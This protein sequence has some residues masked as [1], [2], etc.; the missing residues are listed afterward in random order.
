M[1]RA[2]FQLAL[3]KLEPSNWKRFEEF[4]SAFLTTE[5]AKLRTVASP[6]G[7]EGRDAELFSA[8]GDPTIVFQYSVA[9]A[10]AAKVRATITKIKAN[11][12]G[13]SLLIYVTNQQIGAAADDL[14]RETRIK[15]KLI[16][17]IFDRSYFLDRF[18]GDDHRET[19]AEALA[20]DVVDQFLEGRGVIER[21][22]Q[23]L[24]NLEA[25]AALLFLAL[26][27]EDDTREKG[28][29]ALAFEALVR[30]ALRGTDSDRKMKRADIHSQ[31]SEILHSHDPQY[32]TRQVNSALRRLTKKIVR[33]WQMDDEFCLTHEERLRLNDRLASIETTDIQLSADIAEIVSSLVPADNALPE[34]I[35]AFVSS[36]A[37]KVVEQFLL[38]RGELFASALSNG[39]L[40]Q[41]GIAEIREF[42]RSEASAR[43]NPPIPLARAIDLTA[44]VVER[45]LLQPSDA[46]ASYLREISD[47]YTLLAFLKQTPDVQSAIKKMFSEGEIW[48]DTS[49][50]LPWFAE[51]LL[52]QE[53][54]KFRR[55]LTIAREAGL[56]L[57]VTPGVIKEVER[58]MNR[59]LTCC[60]MLSKEWRG[61]IPFLLSFYIQTGRAQNAFE[62]WLQTFRGE[63]RPEDDIAEYLG[64]FAEVQVGTLDADVARMPDELRHAVKEIWMQI[65]DARR[66]SSNAE[67]D[68]ILTLRL[69]DHDT[70]NYVG[71]IGRRTQ[72]QESAFGYTCWWLTID[73]MA[74]SIRDRVDKFIGQKSPPSP[75][76][77]ADFLLNY[78]SFGPIRSKVSKHAS[79]ILPVALDPSL[80]EYLTPE[81]LEIA[82]AARQASEGLPEHVIRRKVRDALDQARRRVGLVTMQGF[83]VL[84][85][86]LAADVS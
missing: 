54:W 28:L 6:S 58:H 7:D 34:A 86:A 56:K 68:S 80:V 84:S 50:L 17:D 27:W 18:E 39:Q 71:V 36:I 8:E 61:Q 73:H 10:W 46:I 72:E 51:E 19:I 9:K 38:S 14:K 48:M 45:V 40:H 44:V 70:E 23:A 43:T 49:I 55:M 69:A 65:H 74:F 13:T 16:L 25:Q 15:H 37:R 33:H 47:A 60:R 35:I 31:V 66:R 76:M 12:P 57:R 4:A 59:C 52:P 26:Q 75:A 64:E 30:S 1:N 53:K 79:G 41:L 63:N 67:I 85:D 78:L 83:R 22:G 81:L 11:L 3:E 77:S 42:T 82:N 21:K 20:K 5:F 2:R 24:S 29:T 62:A 32:V